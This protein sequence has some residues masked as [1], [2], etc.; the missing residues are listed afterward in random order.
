MTNPSIR[1][2]FEKWADKTI[3]LYRVTPK[4]RLPIAL[5]PSVEMKTRRVAI[6]V[7]KRFAECGK[8]TG[9]IKEEA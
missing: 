2:A 4:H 1:A 8:L 7:A 9:L 3:S 5:W 6:A